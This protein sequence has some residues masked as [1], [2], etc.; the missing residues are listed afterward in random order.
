MESPNRRFGF[1]RL[2]GRKPRKLET[3]NT[4]PIHEQ[5]L[6]GH[7]QSQSCLYNGNIPAEIRNTIF[8]Y[9]LSEYT[10]TTGA[11]DPESPRSRYPKN[12]HYTRPNYE[13]KKTMNVALLQTCRRIYLEAY[14]IPFKNKEAVFFVRVFTVSPCNYLLLYGL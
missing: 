11:L 13:G 3:L 5:E 10:K 4:V 2:K 6:V 9:A 1:P 14:H 12:T 7:P 8:D